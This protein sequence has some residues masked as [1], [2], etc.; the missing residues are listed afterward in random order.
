M[1]ASPSPTQEGE[2]SFHVP[3]ANKP[4]K[5]WYQ[6]YGSLSSSRRPLV[7]LHG[8]PGVPHNYLLSLLDLTLPPYS[9]P[10]ILYDQLGC[11]KSTHLPELH[12][13]ATFWTVELFL[14]ELSNLL[15]HLGIQNNYDL[16]GQSWGGMLGACHAITQPP[17]LHRLVIADSP[18]DMVQ[19]VTVA[20]RLRKQL[21]A[22]IQEILKR[23]EDEGREGAPEYE[24]AMMV[25]YDR[26]VCR[27]KPMPAEL[28]ESFR[29]L[30]E[31][32]TVYMTMSVPPSLHNFPTPPH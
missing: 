23:C 11:G 16:L 12:G 20:D 5:T 8:G 31:D 27:L 10:L 21:P 14:S 18:A 28:E 2:I 17:G 9:I 6:L 7:A 22:D 4:C 3:A 19:W 26:H 15:S 24:E 30:K 29:L 25:Y 32:G 13:S 1:S